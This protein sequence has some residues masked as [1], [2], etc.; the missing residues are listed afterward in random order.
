MYCSSFSFNVIHLA[1]RVHH[2]MSLR[3]RDNDARLA[4]QSE[5]SPKA[6][7][8]CFSLLAAN[9]LAQSEQPV[10][11]T[12]PPSGGDIVRVA[13]RSP[14]FQ[15]GGRL[16]SAETTSNRS[17]SPA[18]PITTHLSIMGQT[19]STPPAPEPS[20][21]ALPESDPNNNNNNNNR[22]QPPTTALP[23][24]IP[25]PSISV[26]LFPPSHLSTLIAALVAA[27]STLSYS[28]PQSPLDVLLALDTLDANLL[29]C[30]T[31]LHPSHTH[32]TFSR[33]TLHH[34]QR[35]LPTPLTSAEARLN[36]VQLHAR[37]GLEVVAASRRRQ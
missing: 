26:F 4:E 31:H 13:S 28:L 16:S 33:T 10:S 7:P 29:H 22:P 2:V 6:R 17:A 32:T 36:A 8:P 37:R 11:K 30:L 27:A 1:Q 15:L 21:A 12:T 25:P 20:P 18:N 9:V 14:P 5:Q 24:E 3:T 34:T 23:S 19:H 35:H